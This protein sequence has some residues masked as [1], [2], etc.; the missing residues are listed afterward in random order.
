VFD[1][2]P[3]EPNIRPRGNS[4][5]PGGF[6]YQPPKF[7][8][9]PDMLTIDAC[10]PPNPVL[11]AL[12]LRAELNLYKIR[13]CRSITGERRQ[14]DPY[15]A[16][17]DT[18]SGMPAIGAGGQ[19]VLP[20][21]TNLAPTPY[22]FS[23]L[24]ER[25]R[26]LVQLSQ[27]T[28]SAMFAA[29]QAGDAERYTAFKAKQDLESARA[30]VKLQTLRV[31]EA[32]SNIVLTELYRDRAQLQIQQYSE[33]L[34]GGMS[35]NEQVA[36]A[37]MWVAFGLYAGVAVSYASAAIAAASTGVGAIQA[38]QFATAGA[39]TAAQASQ[40]LAQIYQF[41]QAYDEKRQG[42]M[43]QRNL[44]QQDRK[45]A[46][47][48]Y[49]VAQD[50]KR[51][52]LQEQT[53]ASLTQ[54]HASATIEF[55]SRKFTNTDLYDWM[56]DVLGGVYRYFL[57]Q[58]TGTARLAA[59]QLAFERQ[60]APPPFIQGDYWKPP[61]DNASSDTAVDRRGLTGSARLLQDITQLEQYALATDLRKLQLSKTLSLVQ[62]APLEFQRFRETG[63]LNFATPMNLFDRDF[64]GHY[65]RLIH[66][67][68]VSML[69][70]TPP[71]MGIRATLTA[72]R[73]SRV[74]IGGD[75]FDT[76]RVSHGPDMVALSSA[77]ESTGLF[78]MDLQPTMLAPF[79][80]IGVDTTWELRMPRAANPFDF[81]SIGDV[82]FTIE[83]T[84]LNSFD[85]QQQVVARLG[86]RVTAQR[87]WSFRYQLADQWY[88]LNNPS[89]SST[90]MTVRFTTTADNFPPNVDPDSL[91][92]DNL[93]LQLVMRNGARFEIPR[94]ALRFRSADSAV[95]VGGVASTLDGTIST[96]S[97]SAGGWMT[98]QTRWP[99]GEW[100]LSLPNTEDVRNR[101]TNGDLV[102][103]ML[104]LT[105]SAR[106]P[107][108]P[109]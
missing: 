89:L 77:R 39:S 4:N 5:T 19:L 62:L 98:M 68:R 60:E 99:I 14:V 41:W 7:T 15:S 79:E 81:N 23:V 16:P 3:L 69:A 107:E 82:L 6:G 8:P 22:R 87:G 102:D 12:R 50:Q 36:I 73:L 35:D 64:P 63:V 17:T 103:V 67:V 38:F 45:I 1:V 97:G 95:F 106:L 90:P 51:V 84:A 54:D 92:I 85:Y 26:N 32:D 20:G 80:N 86:R 57:Q 58:A 66:R 70:L 47:Q 74:V 2:V 25:A 93:A 108:W 65:L 24:I 34:S 78:E 49:F 10:V 94:I 43:F 88:E 42:W 11:R 101:F 53:I 13:T 18:T 96:A 75:L 59:S 28:E 55:L 44:A 56:A 105:F 104:V 83:Y 100:E 9:A 29:I 37:A 61:S 72:G 27:Q 40:Q 33:W 76:V 91:T 30:N 21:L 31:A 52:V 48:Q 71:A 46:E 109:T